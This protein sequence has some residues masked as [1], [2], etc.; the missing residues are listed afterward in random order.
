LSRL[1]TNRA[2]EFS[3]H[4]INPADTNEQ[5]DNIS[6][7]VKEKKPGDID[8]VRSAEINRRAVS[9]HFGSYQ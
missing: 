3:F 9:C 2:G 1:V 7:T 4:N 6:A 8:I 5:I